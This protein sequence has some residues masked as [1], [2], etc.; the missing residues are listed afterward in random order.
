V[1]TEE[2]CETAVKKSFG[3]LAQELGLRL[4]RI[5]EI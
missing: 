4:D 3:L 2:S 1:I 5:R